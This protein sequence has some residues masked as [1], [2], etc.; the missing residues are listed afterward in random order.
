MSHVLQSLLNTVS[1]NA[2]KDEVT[3]ATYLDLSKAFDCLQYDRLFTKMSSLGF[4][5]G[6]LKWFKRYL[7]GRKQ[8]TDFMGDVSNE[9][10]FKVAWSRWYSTLFNSVT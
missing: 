3:I 9:L 10:Y 4:T 8:C 6:T 1:R 2:R 7:A 5:E